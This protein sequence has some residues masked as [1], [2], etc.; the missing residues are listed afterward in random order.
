VK[1]Y[2]TIQSKSF[3][4]DEEQLPSAKVT[5]VGVSNDG[6]HRDLETNI[7]GIRLGSLQ[8]WEK[9][10]LASDRVAEAEQHRWLRVAKGAGHKLHED[11]SMACFQGLGVVEGAIMVRDEGCE[12]AFCGAI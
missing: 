10:T 3:G 11:D 6:I 8:R 1:I 5:A 9:V 12:G 7:I 4:G 2:L